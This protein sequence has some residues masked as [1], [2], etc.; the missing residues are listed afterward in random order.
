MEIIVLGT[1]CA[2]CKVTLETVESVVKE[3]GSDIKVTKQDDII[4][5]VKYNIM[6]LPALV[7]NGEVTVKGYVPSKEEVKELIKKH[8]I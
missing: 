6:S 2:K 5:I 3:L 1:G 4:E 7:I 8:Q